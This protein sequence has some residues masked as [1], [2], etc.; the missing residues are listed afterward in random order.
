MLSGSQPSAGCL[1]EAGFPDGVVN[2][3]DLVARHTAGRWGPWRARDA[4]FPTGMVIHRAAYEGVL[5]R[6]ATL[7]KGI[8]VGD[9]FDTDTDSDIGP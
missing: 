2:I 4:G 6:V 7:V 3:L 5:D 1:E 9:P 8:R